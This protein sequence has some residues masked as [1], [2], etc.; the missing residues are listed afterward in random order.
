LAIEYTVLLVQKRKRLEQSLAHVGRDRRWRLGS[1][2]QLGALEIHRNQFS[3][4]TAE[5]D[6]NGQGSHT[7][8]S[9]ISSQ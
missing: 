7:Q 6:E 4:S 8:L 2:D 1:A 3:E 9:V 5:I